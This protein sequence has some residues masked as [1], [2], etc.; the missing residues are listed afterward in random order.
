MLRNHNAFKHL[1]SESRIETALQCTICRTVFFTVAEMRQHMREMH[2]NLQTIFCAH[3]NCMQIVE[4]Y[5]QLNA[6]WIDTH[7][8]SIFQCLKCFKMFERREFI[9]SHMIEAHAKLQ[10]E[11]STF[12]KSIDMK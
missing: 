9:E 3:P 5:D 8:K 10:K 12:N 6:H 7:R 4:T 2:P 11:N 1:Q